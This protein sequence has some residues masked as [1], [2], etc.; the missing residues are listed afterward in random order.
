MLHSP[1]DSSAVRWEPPTERARELIR[2]AAKVVV[3]TRQQ[4]YDELN[5]ATLSSHFMRSI[6]D[7]PLAAEAVARSNRSNQMHWAAA[8][9][10]HPGQP[11]PANI[12]AETLAIARYLVRRGLNEA[13]VV[14]AYRLAQNVALRAWMHTVFRLTS[15]AQEMRELFD[16][17]ERSI[18]WFLGETISAIHEQMRVER[19]NLTSGTHAERRETVMLILDGARLGA[20]QAEMRLGYEL[21]HSHTAAIIWG[22]E[23]NADLSDLDQAAELLIN[24]VHGQRSLSVLAGADTRWVWLPGDD[25][26]DLSDISAA[27]RQLPG[28]RI[29]VGSTAPGIDGFRRS[30]F[31][32]ISTQRAMTR[33]G[34]AKQVA[35]FSDIRFIALF[36]A[37]PDQANQFIKHTLGDFESADPE[38]HQTVLAYINEQCN[39][40]RTASRLFIHRNTLVRRLAEAGELLPQPLEGA[41]VHV[42]LALEALRWRGATNQS[43]SK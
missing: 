15:D 27:M 40:S 6:A 37:D 42:A 33:I 23:A 24:T 38:L 12:D 9:I 4:W 5:K 41:T 32:A 11:V 16:V 28:V 43:R 36:T 13:V 1:G 14:E 3:N 31:D 17:S 30:H 22:D 25:G 39:A 18:T 26:P 8:N 20:G 19:A 2:Q 21:G 10:S 29:A 7:D 34:L 35:S